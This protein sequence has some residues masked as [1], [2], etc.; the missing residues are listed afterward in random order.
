[1]VQGPGGPLFP[2][3]KFSKWEINV[4]L[5]RIKRIT[6]GN[7]IETWLRIQ[8]E[9]PYGGTCVESHSEVEDKC[10]GTRKSALKVP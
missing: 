9:C 1:M 8:N 5:L 6:N 4:L 2:G 3:M 10:S 7:L